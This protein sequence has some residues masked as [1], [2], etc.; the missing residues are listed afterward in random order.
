MTVISTSENK[1]AEAT[2]RLGAHKVR[3]AAGIAG[4]PRGSLGPARSAPPC[5]VCSAQLGVQRSACRLG[6]TPTLL[7][8]GGT[9]QFVPACAVATQFIVSKDEEQMKAAAGTLDGI[10]DTVSGAVSPPLG[11]PAQLQ[12]SASCLQHL[13]PVGF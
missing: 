1:R 5:P 10:V 2:E 13:V 11:L 8:I 12:G 7:G 3:T 6:A 4:L 9:S